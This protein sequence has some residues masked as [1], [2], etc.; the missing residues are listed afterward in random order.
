MSDTTTVT[1]TT[2]AKKPT[3]AALLIKAA[4]DRG[5]KVD[6]KQAKALLDTFRK[7]LAA[8]DKAEKALEEATAAMAKN[9]EEMIA[10]FGDKKV[11][12]D[13][14]TFFPSS[15]GDTVFYRE[16]RKLDE[17]SIIRG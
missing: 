13:E 3:K 5:V 9:A 7:G 8:R 6:P 14:R 17:D 2:N 11:A 15:R 10:M 12:I 1:E 16:L 4:K